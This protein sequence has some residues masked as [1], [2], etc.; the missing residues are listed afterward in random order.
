MR[1]RE[2]RELCHRKSGN[3][4][5]VPTVANRVIIEEEFVNS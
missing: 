2:G 3:I 4:H 1:G 5:I